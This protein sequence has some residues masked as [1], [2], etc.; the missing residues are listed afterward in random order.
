MKKIDEQIEEYKEELLK[1]SK[2]DK[3]KVEKEISGGMQRLN[4]IEETATKKGIYKYMTY[5]E[6]TKLLLIIEIIEIFISGFLNI[7][8]FFL[9]AVG[10]IFLIVGALFGATQENG[11]LIVLGAHGTAGLLMMLIPVLSEIFKNPMMRDGISIKIYLMIAI[12]FL[13]LAIILAVVHNIRAS[14]RQKPF[15]LN[16]I[17]LFYLIGI[18]M[19][20]LLPKIAYKIYL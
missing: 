14:F 1:V 17:F 9:F 6:L 10:F 11:G 4:W 7:H 16:T 15:I 8:L 20:E 19:I 18:F 12:G 5:N 13:I 3:N 2:I